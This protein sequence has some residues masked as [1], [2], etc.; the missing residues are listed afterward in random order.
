MIL[1]TC[2]SELRKQH[3]Q[4][5]GKYWVR[6]QCKLSVFQKVEKF[7]KNCGTVVKVVF[8]QESM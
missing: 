8:Y 7:H 5:E 1:K 3:V 4:L 6:V 2:F